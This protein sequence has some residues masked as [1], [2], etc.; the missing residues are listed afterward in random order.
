M[1]DEVQ[2]S[3]ALTLAGR[4]ADTVVAPGHGGAWID[5]ACVSCGGCVDSCPTGALAERL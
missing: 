5:S 2:G 1:C 3:F 4:G